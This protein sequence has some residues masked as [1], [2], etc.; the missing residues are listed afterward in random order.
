MATLLP[1]SIQTFKDLA[2]FFVSQFAVNKVKKLE[3]EE[4]SLKSYLAHFNNATVQVDDPV[5]KFFVKA[6]QKG[7]RAGP[8]SDALALRKP[9]SMEEICIRAEKHVEMQE[10]QYERRMAPTPTITF[11]ERDMRRGAFGQDEPMVISIAVA[12]Y[13]IECVLID[14]GSSANIFY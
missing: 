8:F 1:R 11:D 12:G 14:Q 9:V 2:G 7:L 4:E 13:K 6:F 10:D 3:A 5:Q